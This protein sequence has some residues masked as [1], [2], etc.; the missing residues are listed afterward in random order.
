MKIYPHNELA[1]CDLI[2]DAIYEGGNRGN[3]GDDP[4]NKILPVGNQGGFL[5]L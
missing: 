1:N 3:F 2:I 5:H 4:I